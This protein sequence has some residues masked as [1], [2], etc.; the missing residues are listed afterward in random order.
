MDGLTPVAEAQV[1]ARSRPGVGLVP[2]PT[3]GRDRY[4]TCARL[5]TETTQLI[6]APSGSRVA[7]PRRTNGHFLRFGGAGAG[8]G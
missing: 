7:L 2:R 8:G 5:A 3:P 1:V 6:G 4:A